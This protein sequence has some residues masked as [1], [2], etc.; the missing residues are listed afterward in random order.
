MY[1]FG[2]FYK[3]S[4]NIF[5]DSDTLIGVSAFSNPVGSR[6]VDSIV[7]EN[8]LTPNQVLELV[9]L[10]ILDGYGKN[11][12]SYVIGQS[13]RWLKEHAKHVKILISYADPEQGHVGRIYRATNW[14][15]QGISPGKLM[16][17]YSIRISEDGEWTHSRTVGDRYGSR[18]LDVLALKIGHTFWRKEESSK[19]RYIYFLCDRKERKRLT[20]L[21]K[22]P[23]LPYSDVDNHQVPIQKITVVD[24]KI[25]KTEML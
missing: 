16:P 13:L 2:V 3:E 5:F 24:G 17:D 9:R 12:E 14:L 23:I 8:V 4:S 1:A 10:H 19:H 22:H 11:I 7:G 6:V 20:K 21:L 15:Y 18:N 25:L